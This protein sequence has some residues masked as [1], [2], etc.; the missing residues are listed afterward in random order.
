MTIGYD[1]S[2]RTDDGTSLKNLTHMYNKCLNDEYNKAIIKFQKYPNLDTQ[3]LSPQ[4]AVLNSVTVVCHKYT[5]STK[6]PK[7]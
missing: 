7:I 3:F 1:R 2:D 5:T 4:P 6:L